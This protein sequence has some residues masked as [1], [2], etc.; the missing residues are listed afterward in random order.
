MKQQKQWKVLKVEDNDYSAY[1]VFKSGKFLTVLGTNKFIN[2]I[3]FFGGVAVAMEIK[4]K[5]DI[6]VEWFIANENG[7]VVKNCKSHSEVIEFIRGVERGCPF[8]V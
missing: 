1:S 3:P 7:K 5:K 8:E 4:T 6:S 2:A